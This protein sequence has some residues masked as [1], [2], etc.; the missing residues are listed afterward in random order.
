[1]LEFEETK[2]ITIFCTPQKIRARKKE[3]FDQS[4]LDI[5]HD[6]I[7]LQDVLEFYQVAEVFFVQI[8]LSIKQRFGNAVGIE[9]ND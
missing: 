2:G 1:M 3:Q 8:L 7:R 9:Q 4:L 6:H 5:Q